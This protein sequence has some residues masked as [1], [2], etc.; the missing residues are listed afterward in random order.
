MQLARP[1]KRDLGRRAKTPA[2]RMSVPEVG[3][4][5]R[6]PFSFPTAL[7]NAGGVSPSL[8]PFLHPLL[9]C[10]IP[11]PVPPSPPPAAEE[12]ASPCGVARRKS[13]ATVPGA[14]LRPYKSPPGAH[15]PRRK[16]LPKSPPKITPGKGFIHRGEAGS[17]SG[18]DRRPHKAAD[19][20]RRPTKTP[21]GARGLGPH[22]SHCGSSGGVFCARHEVFPQNEASLGRIWGK[23]K[24]FRA[25]Q[26][27][28]PPAPGASPAALS[29]SR[30]LLGSRF[31][32]PPSSRREPSPPRSPPSQICRFF[33]QKNK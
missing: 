30:A 15:A 17:T 28:K 33:P 21:L 27:I 24:R 18:G 23:S 25:P 22:C 2:C 19:P 13:S 32:S 1:Q 8:F 16:P 9:L 3:W 12:P 26:A 4:G 14:L 11:F 6:G 7:N 31:P 10:S 29:Q 5:L 20:I